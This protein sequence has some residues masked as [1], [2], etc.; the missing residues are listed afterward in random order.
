MTADHRSLINHLRQALGAHCVAGKK[1]CIALSG[2]MDSVVLLHALVQL[3]TEVP[4]VLSAI[5][6]NH[7]ISVNAADWVAFCEKTCLELNVSFAVATLSTLDRAGVGLERAAREARYAVFAAV[8]ADVLCMAHHQNDRAE[9]LL[10][11]LFRGAGPQG[12]AAMPSSRFLN[13]K[14]LIRPFIELPRAEL[15]TWAVSQKL[16][17][18]EDESNQNLQFRRNY[19]RH[20]VLPAVS[21]Q[22]PGVSQVLA[23][24][25]TQMNEQ[26]ALLSRLAAMDA[27]GCEDADGYL[28]ISRLAKLPEDA[29]RN[30]LKHRLNKAGVHIPAARRLDA[31]AAQLTN[32]RLDAAVHVRFGD[33][34]CHLWRDRLWLDRAMN[35]AL[36]ESGLLAAGTL[37]WPDGQLVV[38]SQD[39]SNQQYLEVRVQ[40]LGQGQRFQPAGRCR[41]VVSELLR[42]QGVPPWVRPRLPSLW[43][44]DVLCWVAGLG[45]AAGQETSRFPELSWAPTPDQML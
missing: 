1:I 19:L 37:H 25:A 43:L 28:V 5:H 27:R 7:G 31:L 18:V 4:I 2:G 44:G 23:R 30:V 15:R 40:P 45:W 21:Q 16:Q 35:D 22:F 10:L 12:L 33:V 6:V 36:P 14:H 38:S 8:E 17:W 41:G 3:R 34:G 24:T 26:N 42:E 13:G 39:P 20:V 32:A 9:T 29:L 11:N